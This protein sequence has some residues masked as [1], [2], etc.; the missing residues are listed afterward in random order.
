[1]YNTFQTYDV[2]QKD[3]K[4]FINE[5]MVVDLPKVLKFNLAS[6]VSVKS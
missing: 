6:E 5:E 1:M 2:F 4:A 3:C